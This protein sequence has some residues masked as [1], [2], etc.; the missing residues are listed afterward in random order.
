MT[1][2]GLA[3]KAFWKILTNAEVAKRADGLFQPPTA[4]PDLRILALLQRDGR[5]VDFLM[6]EIDGYPDAQIGAAVREIHGKCRK[7]LQHYLAIEPII[8]QPEDSPYTVPAGFDPGT[9][10]V[11]GNVGGAPP[12]QGSLRHTGWRARAVQLPALAGAQSH[13]AVL[14]PAEVEIA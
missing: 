1:R 13:N 2:I 6:E 4:G 3:L 11:V 12:F 9:I 8:N 14:A 10:R 5:L 7:A